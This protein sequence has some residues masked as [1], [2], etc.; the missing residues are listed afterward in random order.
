MLLDLGALV[1]EM[2]RHGRFLPDG[3]A[4]RAAEVVGTDSE[5]RA[6]AEALDEGEGA[7][8][9]V[10][11]GVAGNCDRCGALHQLGARFCSQCGAELADSR[12][13]RRAALGREPQLAGGVARPRRTIPAVVPAHASP[14]NGAAADE[15]ADHPPAAGGSPEPPTNDVGSGS[16]D[17]E[18]SDDAPASGSTPPPRLPPPPA[19]RRERAARVRQRLNEPSRPSRTLPAG[20]V[21]GIAGG[22]LVI[23][24]GVL[25][26]SGGNGAGDDAPEPAAQTPAQPQEEPLPDD[27]VPAGSDEAADA[28]EP[29]AL[30]PVTD[31]TAQDYDPSGDGS[32]HPES[33]RFA[34]DGDGDTFWQTERYEQGALNKDGVGLVLQPDEPLP[35]RRL[36]LFSN[37]PGWDVTVY[38]AEDTLPDAMGDDWTRIAGEEDLGRRTQIDLDAAGSDFAYY[39]IWITSVPADEGKVEISEAVL[40]R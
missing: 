5:V 29:A 34:V 33:A 15:P 20:L 22:L 8:D 24:L 35:A 16:D 1:L 32:E 30:E 28:P 7:P 31:V 39:L 12:L 21:A 17:P 6:L 23:A 18:P 40:L 3:V 25:V 14:A 27:E 11:A 36:D 37:T 19:D 26:L 4:R 9:L 2:H 10:A 38:G 13:P